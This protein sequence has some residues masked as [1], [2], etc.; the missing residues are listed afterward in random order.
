MLGEIIYQQL[1]TD[2][3]DAFDRRVRGWLPSEST[4]PELIA[5]AAN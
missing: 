3:S 2:A 5:S 1:V 4:L